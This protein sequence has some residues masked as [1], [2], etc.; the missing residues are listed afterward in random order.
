MYPKWGHRW[1]RI[2]CNNRIGFSLVVSY[3]TNIIYVHLNQKKSYKNTSIGTEG[4]KKDTN[5]FDITEFSCLND[6]LLNF[7]NFV[8]ILLMTL[9]SNNTMPSEI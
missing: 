5:C 3:A 4:N 2:S 9:L 8:Q 7:S 6:G 1:I